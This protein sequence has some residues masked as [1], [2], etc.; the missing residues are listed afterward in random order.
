[1]ALILILLGH[2]ISYPFSVRIGWSWIFLCSVKKCLG[3]KETGRGFLSVYV[4]VLFFSLEGNALRES[5]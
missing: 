5:I 1:M 4:G 3:I 2:L